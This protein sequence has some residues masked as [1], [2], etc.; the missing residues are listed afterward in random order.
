[1]SELKTFPEYRLL[2]IGSYAVK[3]AVNIGQLKTDLRNTGT[4]AFVMSVAED[5]FC[6]MSDFGKHSHPEGRIEVL[7]N[8]LDLLNVLR[9]ADGEDNVEICVSSKQEPII[10]F[11]GEGTYIFMPVRQ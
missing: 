7:M 10:L 9:Y 2:N 11:F 5:D 1:M 6:M 8:T 3:T 4:K